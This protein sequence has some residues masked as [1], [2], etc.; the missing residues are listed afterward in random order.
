MVPGPEHSQ[1]GCAGS[2]RLDP[3]IPPGLCL[4]EPKKKR[5]TQTS[6]CDGLQYPR[7]WR[8]PARGRHPFRQATTPA[9]RTRKGKTEAARHSA[10]TSPRKHRSNRRRNEEVRSSTSERS[11]SST[12]AQRKARSATASAAAAPGSAAK[13]PKCNGGSSGSSTAAQRNPEV[14][15]R[16]AAADGALSES[17]LTKNK[18]LR[19]AAQ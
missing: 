12:A 11:V 13:I 17:E 5:G 9:I 3:H 1:G 2:R 10:P 4:R 18:S 14:Q 8:K 19:E 6:R 7:T 15:R 16:G